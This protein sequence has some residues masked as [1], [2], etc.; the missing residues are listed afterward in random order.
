MCVCV[1]VCLYLGMQLCRDLACV[2]LTWMCADGRFQGFSDDATG[3]RVSVLA[4][5]AANQLATVAVDGVTPYCAAVAP[6]V[7]L[8]TTIDTVTSDT[9]DAG[10]V[11]SF[12]VSMSNPAVDCGKPSTQ[13]ALT[14]TLPDGWRVRTCVP[15]SVYVASTAGCSTTYIAYTTWR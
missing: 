9:C 14:S 13:L 10:Q 3:L 5:D 15:I 2:P 6:T 7:T 11:L 8:S 1:F 12:E 4:L